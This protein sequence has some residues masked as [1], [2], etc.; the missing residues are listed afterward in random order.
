MAL[1]ALGINPGDVVAIGALII[2]TSTFWVAYSRNRKSEQLKI[3][4]ELMDRME[5]RHTIV[6]E[7]ELPPPPSTM[8]EQ[9]RKWREEFSNV[10]ES[11][12]KP[13]SAEKV[14]NK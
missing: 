12:L 9:E 13:K 6:K 2:A 8:E 7:L 11:K 3:A 1:E 5:M 4:R 14:C 10:L